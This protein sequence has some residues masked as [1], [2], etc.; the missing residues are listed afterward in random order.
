MG[1]NNELELYVVGHSAKAVK[2]EHNLRAVCDALL[3]G[4]YQLRITDVLEDADA[5][6][7]ANIVA[8]PA[9]IR[10]RPLP[11]RVMV[12]DLSL[13]AELLYGLGLDADA[14]DGKGT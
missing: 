12:G 2:A 3:P 5:A 13:R 6:E 14:D 1:P 11:I 7:A 10:R 4:R 8:T 9:L